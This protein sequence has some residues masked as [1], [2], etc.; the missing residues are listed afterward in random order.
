MSLSIILFTRCAFYSGCGLSPLRFAY[1][2]CGLSPLRFA[3]SGYGLSPLR[4]AYSGCGL[5]PLR[6]AYSGCGPS[7]L[8]LRAGRA[9][10]PLMLVSL[11]VKG[12]PVDAHELSTTAGLDRNIP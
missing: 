4:F 5:S 8:A 3:Y 9:F 12:S 7:A 10:T 6:F 1:S 11:R 2:G